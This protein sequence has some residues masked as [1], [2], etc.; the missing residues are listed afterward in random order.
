MNKKTYIFDL[1][2]TLLDTLQDLAAAVNYALRQNGMP[3]HSIDDIRH[4]VGNEYKRNAVFLESAY[5]AEQVLHFFRIEGCR[6]F[7]EYDQLRVFEK[8]F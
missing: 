4:F 2:G 3:E 7:I 8:R 5:D 6:R 1:D